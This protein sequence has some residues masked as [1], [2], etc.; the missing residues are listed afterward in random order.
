MGERDLDVLE[1]EIDHNALNYL[2]KK[3][4]VYVLTDVENPKYTYYR[5]KGYD[6]NLKIEFEEFVELCRTPPDSQPSAGGSSTEFAVGI[7]NVA[8]PLSSMPS[9]LG[10]YVARSGYSTVDEWLKTLTETGI[11]ECESGTKKMFY[12]YHI[13]T[14]R[15]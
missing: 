1:I 15:K 6:A 12:L 8:S 9:N 13:Q 2:K 10:F 7:F 11:P 3:G 14:S 4:D 5:I